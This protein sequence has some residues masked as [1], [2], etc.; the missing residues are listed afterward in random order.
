MA[1]ARRVI[2]GL[3]RTFRVIELIAQLLRLAK[4]LALIDRKSITMSY[5][6]PIGE[7]YVWR[8]V[9]YAS[10]GILHENDAP[11][12]NW[13]EETRVK[14]FS[15]IEKHYLAT[16]TKSSHFRSALLSNALGILSNTRDT[17]PMQ[18]FIQSSD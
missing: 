4:C 5:H 3:R 10:Q 8:A 15:I 1:L 11:K 13:Q 12:W 14:Q 16:P 2:E 17:K 9:R 6:A 18:H 7:R